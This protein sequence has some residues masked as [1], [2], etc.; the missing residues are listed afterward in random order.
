MAK[1]KYYTLAGT[2]FIGGAL[3]AAGSRVTSDDLGSY[4]DPADGKTKPVKPGELLIE[5]DEAG[6]PLTD[7][8]ALALQGV[9]GDIAGQPIAAVAPFSPNPTRPQ[10]APSQPAG[11]VSLAENALQT[12]PATGVESEEAAAARAEQAENNADAVAAIGAAGSPAPEAPQRR[13]SN[14]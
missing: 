11:G 4:R 8:G 6:R 12:E 10:G 2:S 1:L 3:L 9:L 7:D 13:G 14:K 5:T